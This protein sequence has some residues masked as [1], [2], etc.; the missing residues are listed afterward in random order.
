MLRTKIVSLATY[1]SASGLTETLNKEKK[2]HSNSLG[3]CTNTVSLNLE[4][5]IIAECSRPEP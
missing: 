3:T 5:F 2:S 1:A 4:L